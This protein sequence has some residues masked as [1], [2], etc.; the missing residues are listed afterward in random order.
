MDAVQLEVRRDL[1]LPR[2]DASVDL[3]LPCKM[4]V[5]FS[6]SFHPL[7]FSCEFSDEF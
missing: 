6:V 1:V 4:I 3:E 2:V 5:S 7:Q